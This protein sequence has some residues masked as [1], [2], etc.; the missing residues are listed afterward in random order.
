MTCAQFWASPPHSRRAL[1]AHTW[2]VSSCQHLMGHTPEDEESPH[3][4]PKQWEKNRRTGGFTNQ[5]MI[6]KSANQFLEAAGLLLMIVQL[7]QCSWSVLV[8]PQTHDCS[9]R[10]AARALHNDLYPLARNFKSPFYARNYPETQSEHALNSL[11]SVTE[12]K[13]NFL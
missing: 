5:G 7:A 8:H 11:P 12:E 2:S 1:A 13:L 6:C 3:S 10:W 9:A 4:V